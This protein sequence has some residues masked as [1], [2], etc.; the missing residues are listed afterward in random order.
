MQSPSERETADREKPEESSKVS[1]GVPHSGAI[2][3]SRRIACK[4]K[5]FVEQH[6]NAKYLMLLLL[7]NCPFIISA[8]S[9][10]DLAGP[11]L[12]GGNKSNLNT[13]AVNQNKYAGALRYLTAP[14]TG[15]GLLVLHG[16]QLP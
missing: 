1:E 10:Q 14:D 6:N 16:C 2:Y 3:Q 11:Y 12:A 4:A 15:L 9:Q 7:A 5:L 13:G 8:S